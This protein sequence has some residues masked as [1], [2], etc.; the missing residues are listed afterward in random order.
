LCDV[1]IAVTNKRFDLSAQAIRYRHDEPGHGR[2]HEKNQKK[3]QVAPS[4]PLRER[5]RSQWSKKDKF[6]RLDCPLVGFK[7]P[8][9]DGDW[10]EP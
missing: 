3:D 9:S 1:R 5:D 4:C 7:P 10:L 2:Y 8:S 6:V